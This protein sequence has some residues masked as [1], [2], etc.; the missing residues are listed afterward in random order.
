[1]RIQLILLSL[2]RGRIE[3]GMDMIDP[4]SPARGEANNWVIF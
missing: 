1:M 4:P 2:E 3:V